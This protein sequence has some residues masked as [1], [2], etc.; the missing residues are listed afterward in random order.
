MKRIKSLVVGLLAVLALAGCGAKPQAEFD[1]AYQASQ[2]Q[3]TLTFN[4]SMEELELPA[5]AGAQNAAM[6]SG[7]LQQIKGLQ[8]EGDMTRDQKEK[9]VE[10]NM[11]FKV[12]GMSLPMNMILDGEKQQAYMS[13]EYMESVGKLMAGFAGGQGDVATQ[14]AKLKGKYLVMGEEDLKQSAKGQDVF[15]LTETQD[16]SFTDFVKTLDAKRFEKKE[17]TIAV[18]LKK[19]DFQDYLDS[20]KENGTKEQ[21]QGIKEAAKSFDQLAK[22]DLAMKLNTKTKQGDY[23]LSATGADQAEGMKIKLKMTAKPAAKAKKIKIPAKADTLTQTQ[24][25]ELVTVNQQTVASGDQAAPSEA[26]FQEIV[27]Q[28]QELKGTLSD[29]EISQVMAELGSMLSEEQLKRLEAEL[30]NESI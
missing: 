26:T 25:E 18:T 8:I 3:E 6:V 1:E 23:V 28:V 12:M 30:K 21:Q 19:K 20:I 11:D 7:V 15:G 27:A 13:L 17:D 22:M 10:M 14:M 16:D 9:L 5:E 2:Q 4:A 24:L 29:D